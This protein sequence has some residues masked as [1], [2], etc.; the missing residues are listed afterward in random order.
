VIDTD[1]HAARRA[2][3]LDA[4]TQ[5]FLR[6][7]FKKTSMDD[8]ARAAGLSRQGLYLHF[9][10]KEVLF[11]E[12]LLRLIGATR[13]AGHAA[14]VR[15]DLT[16]EH[17]LLEMFVAI[18][19]LVIGQPGAEHLNELLQ[20]AGL[21]VGPAI[22]ELEQE[23]LAELARF[24]RHS[25]VGARWKGVTAKDLAE[26]LFATSAGFKHRVATAA[27]YRERMGIAIRLICGERRD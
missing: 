19:G 13:A 16:V 27:E 4:A 23:Q 11:K 10:T 12:G 22:A 9:S 21:L 14:L 1:N 8:V 3:I 15:E 18:H 20:T 2:A 24:L 7:G 5:V 17:R 6:Y 25:G 26:Q